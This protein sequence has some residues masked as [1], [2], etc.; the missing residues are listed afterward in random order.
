MDDFQNWLDF[1]KDDHQFTLPKKLEKNFVQ[2]KF[3]LFL[4][5]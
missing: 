4:T 3:W 5:I 1:V 2:K